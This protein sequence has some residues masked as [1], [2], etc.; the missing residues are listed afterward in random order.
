VA[1]VAGVVVGVVLGTGGSSGKAG[2]S[3]SPQTSGPLSST[4][5]TTLASAALV[6]DGEFPGALTTATATD[7]ALPCQLADASTP[8][9]TVLRGITNNGVSGGNI[10]NE[11]VAVLPTETAAA[12]L[13]DEITQKVDGCTTYSSSYAAGKTDKVTI[14]DGPDGV[15]VGD[16]SVY[17]TQTYAP[18]DY[19]G[20]TVST[21]TVLVRQGPVIIKLLLAYDSQADAAKTKT[22]ARTVAGRVASA[23]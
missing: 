14:S 4:T 13:M 18:Q 12:D 23:G 3:P 1:V 19:Q 11:T 15:G 20:P 16:D 6:R 17:L 22:L 21:S 2:P 7:I 9:G 5:Q 8:P 10:I